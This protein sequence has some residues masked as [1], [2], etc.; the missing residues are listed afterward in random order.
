[1]RGLPTFSKYTEKQKIKMYG[2]VWK[3]KNKNC[4]TSIK[5]I[6][7]EFE[8]YGNYLTS[9]SHTNKV[10][11]NEKAHLVWSGYAAFAF[12]DELISRFI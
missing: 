12:T 11:S 6:L 4:T 8:V 5:T 3:M 10:F 2:I 7:S 9:N 1:M